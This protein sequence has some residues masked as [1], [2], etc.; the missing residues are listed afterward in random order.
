[1]RTIDDINGLGD[2][3]FVT[4]LAGIYESSPWVAEAGC[5][6][7]PFASRQELA[8][9]LQSVVEDAPEATQ[10]ELIRVHP[11]LGGKLAREG[12]L[13]EESMREQSRHGLDRLTD[14]EFERFT[15]LNHSY[16][17]RFGFPFIICVGLVD[18]EGILRSFEERLE[19]S[20]EEE[21]VEALRQIHLIAGLRLAEL[22]KA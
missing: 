12:N 2:A 3:D 15:A 8:A 6:L 19:H 13:T 20:P 11:D 17:E 14:E 18:R 9:T 21:R 10:M 1:M 5:V 4:M 7:R 16:R 22:V